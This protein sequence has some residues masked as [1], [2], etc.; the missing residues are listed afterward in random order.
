MLFKCVYTEEKVIEKYRQVIIMKE[1]I[2]L[3]VKKN[4]IYFL[5]YSVI[6]WIYEVFLEVVVYRWGFSDRGVLTGPYCPVYGFGMIIFLMTIYR[7]IKN[8]NLKA[9]LIMIPAVF[10]GCALIATGVELIASYICEAIYGSWP[11]QTYAD[12]TYNF[13]A[14]IALS[15]SVRFGIGG[16]IM[17]YL[18][19]PLFE[20]GSDRLTRRALDIVFYITA[21]VMLIDLVYTFVISKII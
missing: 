13:Q 17:L 8:K 5:A 4:Y 2:F 10:L 12:Y 6:G 18:I 11:W 7:I 15:P 1:K 16:V 19:Q 3:A 21:A 14:R 20:K 9:K